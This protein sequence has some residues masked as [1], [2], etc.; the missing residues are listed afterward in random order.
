M[1][2]A[3]INARNNADLGDAV[4][5]DCIEYGLRQRLPDL[6]VLNCD[7]SGRK[8]SSD[9]AHFIHN[10]AR[11]A[12]PI[13][14]A[15]LR[16]AIFTQLRVAIVRNSL[17]PYYDKAINGAHLAIV[18][19][20]EIIAD[21]DEN[22]PMKLAAA[23]AIVRD[24]NIPIAIHAVGVDD[25]WSAEGVALFNEA[26]AGADICWSSVRDDLSR[27]RWRRHFRGADIPTPNITMDPALLAGKAF[28]ADADA[29]PHPRRN[30]PLIGLCVSDPS[31]FRT[32]APKG[33]PAQFSPDA[34]FYRQCI[35]SISDDDCD[36]LLFT[37]GAPE[38]EA[39]LRRCAPANAAN[40]DAVLIANQSKSSGALVDTIRRC[41][42]VVAHQL[43]ACIIAHALK[44]PH[45]GVAMNANLE[46]LFDMVSRRDFLIERRA[47]SAETIAATVR[48]A[49]ETPIG[50]SAHALIIN[51]VERDFDEL[52]RVVKKAAGGERLIR[53]PASVGRRADAARR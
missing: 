22:Y 15:V 25:D 24:R 37:S 31:N 35:K 6:R 43:Y 17:V 51:R 41:D 46:A 16:R 48:R 14:P 29:E 4:V 21:A 18:G 39:F 26:F 1:K 28:A 45:V 40:D 36:V 19:G 10:L 8:R 34:E 30:R 2:I 20:G 38:D 32:G 42:I 33:V 50:D 9:A 52:A 11:T 44:V 27:N 49:L 47:A 7:L 53:S 23:A 13:T 12:A 5:A 3:F